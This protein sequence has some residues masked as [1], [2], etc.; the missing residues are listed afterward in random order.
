MLK[1]DFGQGAAKISEVKAGGGKKKLADWPGS[2][3]HCGIRYPYPPI[4]YRARLSRYMGLHSNES[5]IQKVQPMIGIVC[6]DVRII[7]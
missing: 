2:T 6:K 5:L 4:L 7:C 3:P 1:I